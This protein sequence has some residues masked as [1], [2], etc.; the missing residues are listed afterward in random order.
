MVD[1][2]DRNRE[3]VR[4]IDVDSGTSVDSSI[5]TS[6]ADGQLAGGV[7][8]RRRA[9]YWTV[10]RTTAYPVVIVPCC[11]PHPLVIVTTD[12]KVD[13]RA[14]IASDPAGQLKNAMRRYTARVT[15]Q[16][17]LSDAGNDR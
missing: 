4:G 15:P 14:T 7:A 5:P 11:K 12:P 16:S 8:A 6:D 13:E 3:R 9:W 1:A 10:G 2:D 17:V